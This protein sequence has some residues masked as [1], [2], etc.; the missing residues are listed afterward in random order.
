[1][2]HPVTRAAAAG[3]AAQPPPWGAILDNYAEIAAALKMEGLGHLLPA[4]AP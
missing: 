2:Q 1:M 4:D 3:L